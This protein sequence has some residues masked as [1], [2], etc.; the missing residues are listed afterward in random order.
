MPASGNFDFEF[1]L[2]DSVSGGSQV[3]STQTRNGVGVSNGIFS[4]NLDFGNTFPGA[5]R[6]LEIRVRQAGGG[7]FTTLSPRQPVSSAPYAVKSINSDSAT[8]AVNAVTANNATNAQ[9]AVNATNAQTAVNFTGPLAGD[10]TGT[11]NSTT[12][13]RLQSRSVANTPPLDGQVLKYNGAASE[14]RPDN[15]NT[16]SGGGGGTITGVTPGTG[17]TGGGAT[18]NVTVGIA[19]SG[20]G[21][22]QIADG[23]VTDPKIVSV[24]GTKVTGAV[25][26]S[27]Q[28]GGVAANQYV[29]TID[30][31]LA[32]ARTPTAGSSNYIQNQNVAPQTASNFNVSGTGTANIFSATMQYNIGANRILSTAGAFNLFAGVGAGQ[33]NMG[34]DN[35]FF[36]RDAGAAN[37]MG[38]ANTFFGSKAG[39]LNTTGE[40]NAFFGTFA[41]GN[42]TM[43]FDNAFFGAF[44][45][46]NNTMGFDNAFFG[47]LTGLSNTIGNNNTI[48]GEKADVTVNNLTNATA[49]GSRAAVGSSNSLVLGSINGV[50]GAAANTNVGIG[51]TTPTQRLHVVGNGLFTGNLT[52]NG[53]L[54]ATLPSGSGNYIQNGAA[55]QAA[56][57]F[58]ISGNGTAGGTLSGGIVNATTQFNIGGGRILSSNLLTSLVVGPN[59]G[60]GDRFGNTFVGAST[61]PANTGERNT[62]IGYF[63]GNAT[64]T[65]ISNVFVGTNAGDSNTTGDANTI[66][67]AS[68]DVGL[69]NLTFAT[70]I[71][72]AAVVSNSNTVVLG[73]AAD[74]VRVPGSLG[75]GTTAPGAELHVTANGGQIMVG[76]A[77]CSSGVASIGFGATLECTNYALSGSVA[78]TFINRPTGGGILFRENNVDQ[79]RIAAGGN[80]GIGTNSPADKLDVD[81]DIRV[82]LDGTNLGCVKDD[83]GTVIAGTCSSD[84]RFKKSVTPFGSVLRGFTK[85]QPVHFYWRTDEFKDKHFGTRQSYGLIAQEVEAIFPE[86]VSTDE[87]GYRVVNYSKLPLLTIQA[88]TEQQQQIES[89]R[90]LIEKLEQRLAELERKQLEKGHKP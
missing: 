87:Q 14:W 50:N 80:V 62:F 84:M 22:T 25:T 16:G 26:N 36:G 43:G 47:T 54:N 18:G 40:N 6:F 44:A 4:V 37:T 85:L 58:N 72:T 45:G 42:N 65:G 79:M 15:D 67:G 90:K 8:V 2:F 17:L 61:G 10:V 41:G 77:G 20:V 52:V 70:A 46:D 68:A 66:I 57:N 28:L 74:A 88:V 69:P 1:A 73:R 27:T 24:S 89:Q 78:N 83:N 76:D 29:Q 64:N 5:Q 63:A 30:P 39:L 7:A 59:T 71:G 34:A 55:L 23:S 86:L 33:V 13:A 31:R 49:L 60:G 12:V 82:G 32:D 21:T 9:N 56:S 51:T 75:I 3:G 38:F 19:N 11:Q 35:S 81:G 48:I 53:T